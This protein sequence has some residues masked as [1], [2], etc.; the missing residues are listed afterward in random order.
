MGNPT[1]IT[2]A[3]A[4]AVEADKL[5]LSWPPGLARHSCLL[6]SCLIPPHPAAGLGLTALPALQ[7]PPGLSDRCP[8]LS[9]AALSPLKD[10]LPDAWAR[11]SLGRGGCGGQTCPW[12]HPS[13]DMQRTQ[14]SLMMDVTNRLL[15]PSFFEVLGMCSYRPLTWEFSDLIW[16][17]PGH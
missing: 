12:P 2:A 8:P 4:T 5:L 10:H 1:V 6:S 15:F 9:S 11:P 3:E 13:W 16:S 17:Q 14:V 7:R